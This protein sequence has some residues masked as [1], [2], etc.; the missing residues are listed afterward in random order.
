MAYSRDKGK[1]SQGKWKR[2]RKELDTGEQLTRTGVRHGKVKKT[3][4]G[5]GD[6]VM[7][8]LR[9]STRRKTIIMDRGGV[10]VNR[11]TVIKRKKQQLGHVGKARSRAG[12]GNKQQEAGTD[13]DSR[14][15]AGK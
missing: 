7:K 13:R 14:G 10:G 2:V 4:D 11:G 15:S 8:W 12:E 6:G 9:G 5:D 3:L 1:G